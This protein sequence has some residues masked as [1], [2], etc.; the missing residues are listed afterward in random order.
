METKK[1]TQWATEAKIGVLVAL[2]V[3][4]GFFG[5]LFL[6]YAER[7]HRIEAINTVRSY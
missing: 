2:V 7:H 1:P 4:G 5:Y 6:S 3:V